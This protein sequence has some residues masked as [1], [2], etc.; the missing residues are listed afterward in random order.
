MAHPDSPAAAKFWHHRATLLA[1]RLNFHHWLAQM[2]PMLFILFVSIALFDLFRREVGMLARWSEFLLLF[3]LCLTGGWAWLRA[4]IHFCTSRQA[5]VRLET[6]MGMQNQLSA[7]D[8]GVLPWPIPRTQIDD[9]YIANWKQIVLPL[10]AGSIFLWGAHLV[11]VKSLKPGASAESITEPPEFTQVQNWI[12]SLKA[13]DLIEPAKLQEMQATL[14][15]LRE[16][17]AQDWYTQSNLEAANSLKELMEQSMNTLSQDLDQADRAVQA[18]QEK[19]TTSNDAAGLQPM[20][21]DMRKAGENLASGNLPLKREIVDQLR[22]GESANDKP[23]SAEQLKSLHERLEKGKLAAQTAP[24]SNG[25]L[26]EEMQQAMADAASGHGMGRRRMLPGSGGLGGGK[27]TA[28]LEL[29]ARDK[30]TTANG[31]TTV[32]NDD[33]SHTAIEETLKVTA[34]EHAVNPAAYHGT[35]T[36]GGAQIEGSGGEA[37]WRSTYDPQEADTLSQFFK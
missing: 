15:K 24:K 29:Q 26:S 10:L 23:L 20:Q 32:N 3:G 27:E 33:M 12:N 19:A 36:A 17:P 31:L 37:V 1:A 16:R 35:Q 8:D 13:E 14:N 9:G 34:S 7:A 5:L 25:G 4:R 18:T 6:I 22:G 21:D 30:A 11:P 2:V 28:P